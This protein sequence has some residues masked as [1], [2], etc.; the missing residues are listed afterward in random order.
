MTTY[1][2]Q[3]VEFETTHEYNGRLYGDVSC[4]RCNGTG[5]RYPGVCWDCNG[6]KTVSVRAYTRSEYDA[7]VVRR[8]RDAARRQAET[9]LR[10]EQSRIESELRDIRRLRDR[11]K[12]GFQRIE[13]LRE[14]HNSSH[15]GYVGE[16][17][18]FQGVVRFVTHGDGD[19]GTWTLTAIDT[20]DG[21]VLYW[22]GLGAGTGDEVPF[23]ARVKAHSVRE[24]EKQTI[25]QRATKVAVHPT[26]DNA[27]R[28]YLRQGGII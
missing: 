16:R 6:K 18:Q 28:S 21:V 7:L 23:H 27:L 14:R 12:L 17:R 10:I 13:R 1:S 15:I 8:G 25:V 9:K 5:Y 11:V 26:I 3:G 4:H 2:S 24:G 19:Y 22:N 20:D